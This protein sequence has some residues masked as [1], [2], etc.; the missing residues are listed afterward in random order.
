VPEET[1]ASPQPGRARATAPDVP[2][3]PGSRRFKFHASMSLAIQRTKQTLNFV[4]ADTIAPIGKA[5]KHMEYAWN[6]VLH[7]IR[8]K[9]R[10]RRYLCVGDRN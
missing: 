2:T 5:T 9:I 4:Y 6:A 7:G 10:Y 8:Q 1:A 3:G